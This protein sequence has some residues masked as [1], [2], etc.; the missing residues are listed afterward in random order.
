[1]KNLETLRIRLHPKL[2]LIPTE[3]AGFQGN[4]VPEVAKE[5]G[6]VLRSVQGEMKIQ[7]R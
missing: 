1:M 2:I 4:K 7:R 6:L 3:L 5:E